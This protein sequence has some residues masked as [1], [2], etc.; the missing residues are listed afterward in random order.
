MESDCAN[1]NEMPIPEP[2]TATRELEHTM[3][4]LRSWTDLEMRQP[5][6]LRVEE[7]GSPKEMEGLLAEKRK[8]CQA[9]TNYSFLS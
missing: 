6:G 5:H 2:I 9:G 4:T 8:R 7:E 3:V 1:Q